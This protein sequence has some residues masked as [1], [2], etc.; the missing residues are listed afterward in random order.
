MEHRVVDGRGGLADAAAHLVHRSVAG[1]HRRGQIALGGG[2]ASGG[3]VIGEHLS[4]H[5]DHPVAGLGRELHIVLPGRGTA[6]IGGPLPQQIPEQLGLQAL[7]RLLRLGQGHR[8]GEGL[9]LS[10]LLIGG[11]QRLHIKVHAHHMVGDRPGLPVVLGALGLHRHRAVDGLEVRLLGRC[12]LGHERIFHLHGPFR[13]AELLLH[14][15]LHRGPE[16]VPDLAAVDGLAGPAL[17][18]H[19]GIALQLIGRLG[20]AA[21]CLGLHPVHGLIQG[22][23]VPSRGG[24]PVLPAQQLG[25]IDAAAG[26]EVFPA[27]R[28]RGLGRKGP[29]ISHLIRRNG[30]QLTVIGHQANDLAAV[31]LHGPVQGGLCLLHGHAGHIQAGHRYIGKDPVG[32]VHPGTQPQVAS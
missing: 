13:A 18:H 20:H 17:C 9:P 30:P 16:A 1:V 27:H 26:E 29:A 21:P 2:A 25:Q 23:A 3:V 28:A 11:L 24:D 15:L 12:L 6:H 31:L 5:Q 32:P 8:D 14:G 22:R 19:Q 10:R 7:L 4:G